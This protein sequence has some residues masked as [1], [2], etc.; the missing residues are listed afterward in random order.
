MHICSHQETLGDSLQSAADD[1][2]GDRELTSPKQPYFQG[3]MSKEKR[4]GNALGITAAEAWL[5]TPEHVLLQET[6]TEGEKRVGEDK[7]QEWQKQ[8]E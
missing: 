2:E 7:G 3:A 5:E 1:R 6:H 8:S 4:R